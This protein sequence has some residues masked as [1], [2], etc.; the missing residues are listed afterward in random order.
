MNKISE[1][2]YVLSKLEARSATLEAA[3]CA[4]AK[5]STVL[6]QG[7]RRA[8]SVERGTDLARASLV[9]PRILI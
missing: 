7:K 3:H 5:S 4:R 1:T 6:T 8:A 9:P 2:K